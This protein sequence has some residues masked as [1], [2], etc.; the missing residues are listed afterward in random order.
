MRSA[1]FFSGGKD[2]VYAVMKAREA[3]VAVDLLLFNIFDFPRPSPHYFNIRVV[4]RISSLM[5]LP[6]IS[7]KVER[8]ME[9]KRVAEI[10]L[11]EGVG[12][13]VTGDISDIHMDWYRGICGPMGIR[14]LAPLLIGPRGDTAGILHEELRSGIRPLI[15]HVDGS[16]L[17]RSMLGEVIDEGLISELASRCDPCGENGEYHT[18]V[19]DAPAMSGRIEVEEYGTFSIEGHHYMQITS[20]REVAKA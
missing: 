6:L 12:T 8:G 15:V 20:A 16:R 19:L 18:L 14:H 3:G 4:E 5:G 2:S 13:I 1:A 10:L 9:A 17:P 7:T 11:S